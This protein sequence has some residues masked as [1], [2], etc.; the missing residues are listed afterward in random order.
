M[1]EATALPNWSVATPLS[2]NFEAFIAN[3]NAQ[4]VA[5]S[6]NHNHDECGRA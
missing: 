5:L 2:Q 3:V 1:Q 6:E 4:G